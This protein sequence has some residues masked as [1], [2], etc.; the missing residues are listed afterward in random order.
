MEAGHWDGDTLPPEG[1]QWDLVQMVW[2]TKVMMFCFCVSPK[3]C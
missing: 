3:Y 1:G 2:V